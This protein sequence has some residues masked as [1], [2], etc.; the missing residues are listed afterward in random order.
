TYDIYDTHWSGAGAHAAYVA[1]MNRVAMDL[2]EMQA[3]PLSHFVPANRGDAGPRDL[4]RMLGFADRVRATQPQYASRPEHDPSR[5]LAMPLDGERRGPPVM[6]TD[7]PGGR[8][9]LLLRDSFG[10]ELLPFLKPHF[11][12]IVVAHWNRGFWR[13]DLVALHK[14]D[15]IVLE[16]V[17][18]AARQAMAPLPDV[19]QATGP[20]PSAGVA[21][22][23]CNIDHA[24]IVAAGAAHDDRWLDVRGWAALSGIRPGATPAA[25]IVLRG[26]DGTERMV[27]SQQVVRLDVARHFGDPALRSAGFIAAIDLRQLRGRHEIGVRVVTNG[28]AHPCP[29]IRAI[30]L[31]G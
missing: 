3:H 9:L 21:A 1:L 26:P 31:G 28:T 14:P 12:R 20:A 2:P 27:R 18:Y 23:T 5:L 30:D 10:V 24:A 11:S 19:P 16:T 6:L 8:T 29:L 7:A 17:E 25:R 15:V 4:A 22:A 13:A